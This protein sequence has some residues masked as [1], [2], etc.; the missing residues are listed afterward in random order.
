MEERLGL[1]GAEY[2]EFKHVLWKPPKHIKAMKEEMLLYWNDHDDS[3]ANM[4]CDLLGALRMWKSEKK[5]PEQMWT[6]TS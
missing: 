3:D 2:D 5:K 4:T 1:T 6:F